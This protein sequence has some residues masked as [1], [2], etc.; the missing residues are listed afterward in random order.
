MNDAQLKEFFDAIERPYE[1]W[2]MLSGWHG[3]KMTNPPHYF[4]SHALAST[5][6]SYAGYEDTATI[7]DQSA[8]NRLVTDML[9]ESLSEESESKTKTPTVRPA[10]IFD[11]GTYNGQRLKNILDNLPDNAKSNILGVYGIDS[12]TQKLSEATQTFSKTQYLF[13][14]INKKI[15]DIKFKE[16]LENKNQRF[17]GYRD[18][19]DNRSNNG[20]KKVILGLENIF[21]NFNGLSFHHDKGLTGFLSSM[22]NPGDEIIL[23]LHNISDRGNYVDNVESFFQNYFEESG[24]KKILGGRLQ[25]DYDEYGKFVYI[26]DINPEVN[27]NGKRYNFSKHVITTPDDTKS[28]T[29]K[30]FIG[31]S[32]AVMYDKLFEF[33]V[34]NFANNLYIPTKKDIAFS[35]SDMVLKLRNFEQDLWIEEA[36]NKSHEFVY[37]TYS[38]PARK[39]MNSGLTAYITL[40]DLYPHHYKRFVYRNS[41]V[42][43]VEPDAIKS[44]VYRA[45][46]DYKLYPPVT[47]AFPQTSFEKLQ[48][49]EKEKFLLDL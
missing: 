41:Q 2:Q 35:D 39:T 9:T 47:T 43:G 10:I 19:F 13:I 21:L 23:E 11:C 14:P 22:T 37:E 16:L 6:F 42:L 48:F 18:T 4:I 30:I 44:F 38:S 40:K 3:Q 46:F 34:F 29:P 45:R 12:N 15:E 28:V 24:L 31:F 1:E 20:P 25:T 26:I 33:L 7:R 32:G 5:I 49:S 27:F 36:K 8:K 17:S